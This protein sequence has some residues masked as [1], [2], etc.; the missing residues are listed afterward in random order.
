MPTGISKTCQHCGVGGQ[1]GS[2]LHT[3]VM[4]SSQAQSIWVF[5]TPC[6]DELRR[7]WLQFTT[8]EKEKE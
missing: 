1:I 2:E 4:R 8:T 5:C 7:L 3:I 6:R